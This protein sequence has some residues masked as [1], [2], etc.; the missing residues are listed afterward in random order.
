MRVGSIKLTNINFGAALSSKQMSEYQK[1]L[2]QANAALGSQEGKKVLIVH[3][4]SLPQSLNTGVGNLSDKKAQDFIALM[5]KYIGI[6]SVELLPQ[7]QYGHGN[8]FCPYGGSA[9][10]LSQNVINPSLLA[11]EEFG[12]ILTPDEL[13]SLKVDSSED[14]QYENL[15]P[16]SDYDALLRKAYERFVDSDKTGALKKEFEDY[17]TQNADWLEPKSVFMQLASDYGSWNW[18]KWD[19]V[20]RDLYKKD[21]SDEGAKRAAQRIADIKTKNESEIDFFAFKQ[22]LADN[23]LARAKKSL[24]AEGI[25]LIGDCLIG[26]GP[27]EIWAN[28]E[29]F[30]AKASVGWGIKSIDYTKISNSDGT[31]GPTG[32]FLERKFGAFLRRYDGVRMDVG[33]G[34]IQPNLVQKTE[35]GTKEQYYFN[36]QK[37]YIG[38]SI[39]KLLEGTAKKIKGKDF[40][41]SKIMYETECSNVDF[42]A[43]DTKG[44][45][46]PLR[47]RV[48]VYTTTYGDSPSSLVR[49]GLKEDEFIIGAGNHDSVALRA[50]ANGKRPYGFDWRERQYGP[51]SNNMKIDEALLRKK[52]IEFS[53][54]KFGEIFSAK[55]QMYFFNDILGSERIFDS[56]DGVSTDYRV[57][58]PENFEEAYHSAIQKGWGLN[59]MDALKK[60]FVAKELDKKQPELFQKVCNF[61]DQLAKQGAKTQAE[62]DKLVENSPVDKPTEKP[63]GGKSPFLAVSAVVASV[64]A[65]FGGLFA[66][67]KHK[68]NKEKTDPK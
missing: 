45:I 53:K 52:P 33:W 12:E 65:A 58:I 7:G 16:H 5:Q 4:A 41:C 30:S 40:D 10:S 54:A 38:D 62:A 8:R 27:D 1:V 17:K 31:L 21:L 51:L 19:E 14:V 46:E 50:L 63:P 35:S 6:N 26:Q 36:N 22:F 66:A 55:H 57:R 15:T 60:A 9:F 48:Q 61:A 64:I 11:T 56:H 3:D 34:L 59:P 29:A 42:Q 43:F 37:N 39:I 68:K 44:A 28:Q 67:S 24:N 47:G 49:R 13:K 18:Q 23:H 2:Q 25:N 32:E 20:D